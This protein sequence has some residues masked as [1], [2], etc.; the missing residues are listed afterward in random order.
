MAQHV[1]RCRCAFGILKTPQELSFRVY[2]DGCMA[3][4]IDAVA[5]APQEDDEQGIR[6]LAMDGR[7]TRLDDDTDTAPRYSVEFTVL[8]WDR[9]ALGYYF[10]RMRCSATLSLLDGL[11]GSYSAG[12]ID[13][14]I[15][16][17]RTTEA[18]Q[19]PLTQQL[20]PLT[21]GQYELRA[22][23]IGANGPLRERF[24][25]LSLAA[26]GS[27]RCT[28][29]ESLPDAKECAL[30]GTWTRDRICYSL[31]S[32]INFFGAGPST[33]AFRCKPTLA[34]IRG[35]W[36]NADG[37]MRGFPS[38][39]GTVEFRLLSSARQ[40]SEQ[41]HADYPEPFRR[42]TRSLLLA[43]LRVSALNAVPSSIWCHVL[44][45]CGFEWF[46]CDANQCP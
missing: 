41:V 18:F 31:Q 17:F 39:H 25:S 2:P 36:A 40:W 22:L 43:S 15:K 45:Y 3:V 46:G 11:S 20:Y 29:R 14:P 27:L 19:E 34:D 35:V 37:A 38:E 42:A 6:Y 4:D 21:P 7:A 9:P 30:Q 26:D 33:Y 8:R 1:L 24:L 12:D 13:A 5:V 28:A 16:T 10:L 32:P 44:S 23:E